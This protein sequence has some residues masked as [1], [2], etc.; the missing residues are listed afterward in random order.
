MRE[1]WDSF[2]LKMALLISTR[3]T[4]TRVQ[5]GAVLT[6]DKRVIST[7]YNGTPAG[8]EHCSSL[9]SKDHAE[10]SRKNEL[11]AELNALLFSARHGNATLG[12]VLYLTLSPCIACA[13]AILQAGV[14]RVVYGTRYD[15]E[16]DGIEFLIRH[17]VPCE[18]YNGKGAE[19]GQAR[20]DL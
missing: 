16:T 11:H 8:D 19:D 4:C 15:R 2:F 3:S 10:F 5:V 20:T 6:L 18:I 1:P 12:A 14:V 13:K 9:D 7:G 17:G